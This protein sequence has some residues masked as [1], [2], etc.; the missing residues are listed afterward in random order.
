MRKLLAIILMVCSFSSLAQIEADRLLNPYTNRWD[1]ILSGETVNNYFKEYYADQ[2]H[3]YKDSLL[4]LLYP[5]DSTFD[6]QIYASFYYHADILDTTDYLLAYDSTN[7][8]VYAVHKDS[9]ADE[10]YW[11]RLNDHLYPYDDLDSVQFKIGWTDTLVGI[12]ARDSVLVDSSYYYGNAIDI[13]DF[14]YY[15]GTQTMDITVFTF[16]SDYPDEFITEGRTGTIYIDYEKPVVGGYGNQFTRSFTILSYSVTIMGPTAVYSI[17]WDDNSNI[18]PVGVNYR[19]DSLVLY[20]YDGFEWVTVNDNFEVTGIT[21][22]DTVPPDD[23]DSLLAWREDSTVVYRDAN[24]FLDTTDYDSIHWRKYQGKVFLK[25]PTDSVGIGTDTPT[26][27]FH[28]DGRTRIDGRLGINRSPF[29]ELAVLGSG[30]VS[31]FSLENSNDYGVH[32]WQN[33]SSSGFRMRLFGNTYSGGYLGDFAENW[34][35]SF[36]NTTGSSM[37][38]SPTGDNWALY[39]GIDNYKKFWISSSG[40]LYADT[41]RP[42]GNLYYPER[43]RTMVWDTLSQEFL[44]VPIDSLAS[45]VDTNNYLQGVDAS[46]LSAVLFDMHGVPDITEDFT[47]SYYEEELATTKTVFSVGFTLTAGTVVLFNGQAIKSGQW[48]GIG[49]STLTLSLDTRQYDHI[50]VKQ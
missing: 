16:G 30:I 25:D 27:K 50:Y 11:L 5:R 21:R 46:D 18:I 45:A 34:Q 40:Y 49:T 19:C 12:T 7:K 38:L 29:Y 42:L 47:Q 3:W 10:S 39:L 6:V 15:P 13:T 43:Y 35:H 22:L 17:V 31:Y 28:I 41:I 20:E 14:N 23:S 2:S 33:N 36:F 8:L 4:Y 9:I 32:F 26:E 48:S 37:I 44:S 1:L 24:F